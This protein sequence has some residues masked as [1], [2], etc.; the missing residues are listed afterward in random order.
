MNDLPL[1]EEKALLFVN[2]I[3]DAKVYL[4]VQ[5]RSG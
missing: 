5:E 3:K 2:C 1:T 4:R